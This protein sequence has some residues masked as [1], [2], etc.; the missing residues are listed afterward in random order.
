M[1][2]KVDDIFTRLAAK[3]RAE[4]LAAE[5]RE[6]PELRAKRLAQFAADMEAAAEQEARDRNARL[7]DFHRHD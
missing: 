6:T 5:A 1:T 3:N 2:T 4:S 7:D